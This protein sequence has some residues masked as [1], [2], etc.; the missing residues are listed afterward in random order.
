MLPPPALLGLFLSGQ[1]LPPPP[2]NCT[3]HAAGIAD[4]CLA[5]REFAA[6]E[7]T[8]TLPDR[9]R[10]LEAALDLYRKGAS[11]ANDLATKIAA[12]DAATRTLDATH[13]NAPVALELTLRELIGLA[14]ND[15]RFMFRL[16][17]VQEDQGEID[18]AEE[19]LL[20]VRR[21]Q[22]QQLE[23]YKMLAQFY[24]RRASAISNQL[25]QARGPLPTATDIPGTRDK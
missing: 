4:I 5:D 20:A 3:S 12:L 2:V 17:A 11:A 6:A 15:L 18:A 14:P 9:T 1:Q 13:L 21:E 25:A 8:R 10:H 16:A 19:T 23:P 24:A 22:P 7:T